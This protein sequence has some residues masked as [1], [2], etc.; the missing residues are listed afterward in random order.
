MDYWLTFVRGNIIFIPTT[1]NENEINASWLIIIGVWNEGL[2]FPCSTCSI[3]NI[4]FSTTGTC[5]GVVL[6]LYLSALRS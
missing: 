6:A 2:G 4:E 1:A 3:W 5:F